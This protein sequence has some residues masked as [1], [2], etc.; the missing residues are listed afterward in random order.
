MPPRLENMPMHLIDRHVLSRLS[1]TNAARLG[2]TS[3][4]YR[5][6]AKRH[7]NAR[8]ATNERYVTQQFKST[9]RDFLADLMQEL[10]AGRG[11]AQ[12]VTL[13]NNANRQNNSTLR[14]LIQSLQVRIS[15]RTTRLWHVDFHYGLPGYSTHAELHVT[16]GIVRPRIRE[17]LY[18]EPDPYFH[19]APEQYM[20]M[21]HIL[22]T[23]VSRAVRDYNA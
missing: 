20:R 9:L 18:H 13:S 7:V 21:Q 15:R 12:T 1:A 17:G 14:A 22:E 3:R 2:A 6:N 19:T 5:A 8:K 4:Q 10:A 16:R 11:L 23:A